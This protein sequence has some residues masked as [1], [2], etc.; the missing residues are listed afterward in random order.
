MT[1]NWLKAHGLQNLAQSLRPIGGVFNEL[2]AL[3]AQTVG[4]FWNGFSVSCA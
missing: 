2:N 3:N 4:H 1:R